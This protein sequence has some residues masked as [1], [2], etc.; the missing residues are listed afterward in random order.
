MSCSKKNICFLPEPMRKPKRDSVEDFIQKQKK[1]F[2]EKIQNKISIFKG[3][4]IYLT[5]KDEP[6]DACFN[7]FAIGKEEY[8]KTGKIDLARIERFNW[9]FE[10]ID[11]YE[12]CEKCAC[13]FT[14]IQND[15]RIKLQCIVNKFRIII[16]LVAKKDHYEII[17]CFYIYN[18]RN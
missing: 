2:Q 7:K 9:I 15:N 8:H 10:I 5:K 3:K 17:S 12:R 1:Y 11:N 16:V 14:S 13:G 6:G 4:P 18:K